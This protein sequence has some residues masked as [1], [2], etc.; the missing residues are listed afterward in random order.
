VQQKKSLLKFHTNLLHYP[1]VTN[2]HFQKVIKLR[3]RVFF[4]QRVAEWL[5]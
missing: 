1:H 5:Y 4:L 2:V 3:K